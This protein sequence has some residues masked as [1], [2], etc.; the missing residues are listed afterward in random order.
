MLILMNR[1]CLHKPFPFSITMKVIR[2]IAVVDSDVKYPLKKFQ[3]EVATYLADPDGWGKFHDFEEN[4]TTYDVMIHLSSPM[5]IQQVGCGNPDLSCA[6]M[7]GKHLRVNA[8]RWTKGAP[9]S[10][11]PLDE[12]RQYV[13]SHEMGHILGYDHTQ[14]PGEGQ[15]AP[16]MMQQTLGIGKCKPNN[17]L[18]Q[19]DLQLRK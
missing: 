13:I 16:I 8:M 6:E 17:K 15:P 14:C 9:E 7:N 12:Y 4:P 10:K 2:Y 11:L 3:S 1:I 18:T 19:I 5:S